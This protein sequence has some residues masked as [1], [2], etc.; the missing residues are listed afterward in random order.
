MRNGRQER[1]DGA[2]ATAAPTSVWQRSVTLLGLVLAAALASPALGQQLSPDAVNF[3]SLVSFNGTT[4][5][6]PFS[7]LVQGTDGNLYGTTYAGGAYNGGTFFKMTP[8]GSL[9]ALYDFCAQRSCT[10]G[11]SPFSVVL[12][13]DGN[14]YGSALFGGSYSNG[15]VFK[16]TPSG[17]LTILHS[18]CAVTHCPDGANPAGLVQGR[19]GNLYGVTEG[20][21]NGGDGIVFKITLQGAFTMLY[22]FCSQP[23]CTDGGVPASALTQGY[24]GDFYGST[25]DFGAYHGG[26]VF[27]MTPTGAL[28]TLYSFCALPICA[29]G[30]RIEGPLVQTPSGD[31]YGTTEAGGANCPSIQ[32]CGTFFRL[33]PAGAFTTLYSFCSQSNCA[34]GQSPYTGGLVQGTDGNFYGTTNYG[35][36][37]TCPGGLGCGTVFEITPSGT[38]T[39]LH[40]FDGTD[41]GLF[42]LFSGLEQATSGNFYGSTYFGG[43][44]GDGTIF[45]LSVALGP[46]V[47]LLP[48]SNKA[49]ATIR[50]LGSNLTG[51]TGVTFNGVAAAFTVVSA[52]QIAATVP[53]GATSGRVEVVT[54]SRTLKSNTRFVVLP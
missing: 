1:N 50:I 9:T 4:G 23:N 13:I 45:A 52:T 27:K 49:G 26:T 19:D 3:K 16:I 5:A 41:A 2:C 22:T 37:N 43:T 18:F 30:W 29:D 12:G 42:Q 17:A 36:A 11:L 25:Q 47:K 44:K 39:I 38:L 10:D 35:G 34:D 40:N 48:N 24:D 33:T 21:G 46:F 20:G 51:A 53:A 15:T 6:N 28:T 14:F 8:G 32:G 54:P 7:N 31:F